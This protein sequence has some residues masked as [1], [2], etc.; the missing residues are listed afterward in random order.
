MDT[1]LTA[2]RIASKLTEELSGKEFRQYNASWEVFEAIKKY[3][4]SIGRK[5]LANRLYKQDHR[6]NSFSVHVRDY[7]GYGNEGHSERVMYVEYNKQK[8]KRHYSSWG[9]DY[10]DWTYKKVMVDISANVKMPT[11]NWEVV[12][13][14]LEEKIARA[15]KLMAERSVSDCKAKNEKLDQLR[16]IQKAL[17]T[18]AE[19]TISIVRMLGCYLD[20]YSYSITPKYKEALE[21]GKDFVVE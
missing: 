19:K 18:D 6:G 1:K 11:G 9:R 20:K 7:E 16:L 8:G 12:D 10:Y 15:D 21:T 13:F 14:D 4:E 5:D 2:E 3:L 17:G